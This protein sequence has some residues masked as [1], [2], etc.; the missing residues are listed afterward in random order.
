MAL[1]YYSFISWKLGPLTIYSYGLFVAIAFLA[2]IFLAVK[3]AKKRNIST[4]QIY[5]LIF[6]IIIASIIGARIAY[7]IE[8]WHNFDSFIDIFKIWEG[9]LSFIGG[10]IGALIA[11]FAYVKLKKLDFWRYADLFTPAIVLG[12]AIGRIGCIL[13]DGGHIG[14]LTSMPFGALVNGEARHL[15][16][17]YEFIFLALLFAFLIK[18]K[19]RKVF[20]KSKG[21]LFLAY[22][23]AYSTGRFVIDL[24]RIDPRYFGLT[25]T[26]WLLTA[27]FLISGC[28]IIKKL[29]KWG[30]KE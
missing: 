22:L 26:Q 12:H 27:I 18:A 1:P 2:G 30:L 3:G 17:L 19:D 4:E 5:D 25:M 14:K 8:Y 13:G 6:Y 7:V 9:G 16:A 24:L 29:R 28:L 15:T 21:L 10:F 20:K 11:V 23:A